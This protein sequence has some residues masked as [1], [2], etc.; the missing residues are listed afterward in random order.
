MNN[1]INDRN[2]FL[3]W[4]GEDNSL[5]SIL[6]KLIYLHSKSGKGYK[7]HLINHKNVFY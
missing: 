4:E 5:I 6:R 1:I 2:V 7:V 3:Y